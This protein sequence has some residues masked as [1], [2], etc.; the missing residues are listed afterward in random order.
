VKAVNK[1]G[2]RAENPLENIPKAFVQTEK[3]RRKNSVDQSYLPQ[4]PTGAKKRL[5]LHFR[6]PLEH[7][8]IFKAGI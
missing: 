3:L 6:Q 8:C 4:K 2:Q 5:K 1:N 7:Q